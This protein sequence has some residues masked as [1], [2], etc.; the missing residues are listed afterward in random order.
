MATALGI[1]DPTYDEGDIETFE[2]SDRW[3][4]IFFNSISS[5][6]VDEVDDDG[7]DDN[8]GDPSS[9]EVS[10]AEIKQA[11]DILNRFMLQENL[12]GVMSK[13]LRSIQSTLGP[14]TIPNW[15]DILILNY[16]SVVTT[17]CMSPKPSSVT[18]VSSDVEAQR[19]QEIIDLLD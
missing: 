18:K 17:P 14:Y 6:A 8:E 11:M 13:Q 15:K 7:D 4:E 19:Q 10:V 3:E 5:S 1:T 9:H 12:S 16:F 2:T